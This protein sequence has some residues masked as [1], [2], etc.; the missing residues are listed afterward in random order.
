MKNIFGDG[1]LGRDV[2]DYMFKETN[3]LYDYYGNFDNIIL[4]EKS[5]W[6]GSKSREEIFKKAISE[7]LESSKVKTYGETR[8]IYLSHLLFGGKLPPKAGF[9][10]GPF[11]LP[12]NRA[13]VTQG[14]IFK[15]AG[16][17]TTFSPSWRMISDMSTND[18]YTNLPGGTTDRRFSKWYVSDIKNWLKGIYKKI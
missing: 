8:K 17:L 11:S 13:T 10:Y 4:N 5:A 1:G 12:G 18:M 14:Q 2:V 7:A 9:D 16:R 3:L 6:Y 15:S